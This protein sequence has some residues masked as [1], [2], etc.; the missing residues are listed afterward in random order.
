MP[1]TGFQRRQ[2]SPDTGIRG[3]P[4]WLTRSPLL[5]RL[6]SHDRRVQQRPSQPMT[7]RARPVEPELRAPLS[8]CDRSWILESSSCPPPG[9]TRSEPRCLHGSSGDLLLALVGSACGVAWTSVAGATQRWL[10]CVETVTI[11]RCGRSRLGMWSGG[12]RSDA[13]CSPYRSPTMP[14]S[15]RQ[16]SAY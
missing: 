14:Q 10:R 3:R 5:G 8:R 16:G 4:G 13:P 12:M 2:R 11:H 9:D 15:T 7:V 6:E 1:S